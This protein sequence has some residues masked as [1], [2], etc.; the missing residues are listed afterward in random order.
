MMNY[1]YDYDFSKGREDLKVYDLIISLA[2]QE[3]QA[4]KE[5]IELD[6]KIIISI[7]TRLLAEEFMINK[8][9]NKSVDISNISKNQTGNLLQLYKK[10]F[11]AEIENIKTMMK[12][13]N[14]L[15]YWTI[16]FKY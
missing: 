5:S 2:R 7:A 3:A 11:S 10:H 8:L 15:A 9:K 12:M 4:P 6:G 13:V 16:K 1:D 14:Y